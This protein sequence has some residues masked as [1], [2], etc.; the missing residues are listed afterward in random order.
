MN[1]MS[2]S[3]LMNDYC[4]L[5]ECTRFVNEKKT[6]KRVNSSRSLSPKQYRLQLEA[7]SRKTSLKFLIPFKRS[8]TNTTY[9]DEK[10]KVIYWKI[11]WHFPNAENITFFDEKCD[12][13][14]QLY[15]LLNKY[16]DSHSTVDIPMKTRLEY[17]QS[18]GVNNLRIL[19]KSE[20]VVRCKN[21][22]FELDHKETLKNNLKGKT[23]VEYPV[24][25]IVFED[26]IKG[27]DLID[28]GKLMRKFK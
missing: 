8:E 16:L 5:E 7:R 3:D 22:F 28:S 10:T 2:K 17:Y 9:Y 1:K 18:R 21:R 24:I 27:F 19:L 14:D 6:N 11:E 12:E 15:V 13:N 4:F 26:S 25:F 23:I 20:G